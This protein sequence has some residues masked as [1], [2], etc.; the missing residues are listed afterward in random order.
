[1]RL[2]F[3][4]VFVKPACEGSSIGMSSADSAAGLRKSYELARQYSG[5]VLAELG[6]YRLWIGAESGSQR[7]LDA[8]L[9]AALEVEDV[10]AL[11]D[12]LGGDQRQAG[13]TQAGGLSLE[14]VRRHLAR[15]ARA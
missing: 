7:L 5:D 3:G 15:R 14:Q 4:K 11:G 6:C 10:V 2:R 9:A 13:L 12:D 1:M 8:M